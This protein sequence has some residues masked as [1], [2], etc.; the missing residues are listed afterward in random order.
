MPQLKIKS[1]ANW[2]SATIEL[3]LAIALQ[4]AG[5]YANRSAIAGLLHTDAVS[6]AGAVKLLLKNGNAVELEDGVIK[7]NE[8]IMLQLKTEL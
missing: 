7:L 2:F 5:G 6:A 1:K 3:N 4:R 8:D